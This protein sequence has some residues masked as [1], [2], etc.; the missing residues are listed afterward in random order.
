MVD[1][2][3]H[4]ACSG[5]CLHIPLG[6]VMSAKIT[7]ALKLESIRSKQP[8]LVM[9][10]ALEFSIAQSKNPAIS[11]FYSFEANQSVEEA[12]AIPDGCIDVLFDCDSSRPNAEV[13]GTP[14]AAIDIQL[15]RQHRYFGVRFSSSVIP[16][17]FDLSAQELIAH[18]YG[19]VD[20][21]PDANQLVEAV[22][23]QA[24]FAHQVSLFEAFFNN[25]RMRRLSALTESIVRYT[26]D[27]Q[28]NVR[29][30]ELSDWT[31]YTTRTIQ[32]Q[33]R[34]D[35]GMSPKAFARIIRCQSA[36]Y[37]INHNDHLAFS[38][39]AFDLGFSD[40]SHF[41]REFKQLVNT[42]PMS[43]KKRI[44]QSNYLERIHCY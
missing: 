35:T 39:I 16:D 36:V 28:G 4:L 14:M 1:W 42:T 12:I 13:F 6:L 44:K 41:L 23:G 34:A 29:I 38:D 8:W 32:R 10:A 18:H 17:C 24:D 22:V 9:S 26:L 7:T 31:G 11:H 37:N 27:H 5:D 30:D 33:F 43:Y 40:Q 15:Q 20:L 25:K 2:N 21:V 19:L 3:W